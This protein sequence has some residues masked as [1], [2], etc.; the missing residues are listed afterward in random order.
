M[1]PQILELEID[2]TVECDLCKEVI[3]VDNAYAVLTSTFVCCPVLYPECLW[4]WNNQGFVRSEF[5]D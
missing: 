5:Y 1:T 4:E 3:E 2:T